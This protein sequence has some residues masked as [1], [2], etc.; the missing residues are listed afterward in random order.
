MC[1]CVGVCGVDGYDAIRLTR[2]KLGEI[3][4]HDH[5]VSVLEQ[6]VHE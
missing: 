1:G 4:N 5:V 6:V 2:L 3:E